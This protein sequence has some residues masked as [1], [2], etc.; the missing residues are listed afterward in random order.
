MKHKQTFS[1]VSDVDVE[2]FCFFGT[3]RTP[4]RKIPPRQ[5]P[6]GE[7]PAE[8]S[9]EENSPAENS[10]VFINAFF[11]YHSLK[12]KSELVIA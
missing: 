10:P 1:L 8:Y 4:P 2:K 12:M 7:F 3:R 9:S 5:T 11:I 6:R